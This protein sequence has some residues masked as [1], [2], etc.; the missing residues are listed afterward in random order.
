MTA[1][2]QND[3]DGWKLLAP[4]GFPD[5]AALHTLV[6]RE[7]QMLPLAGSPSLVIVGREV[8]LGTGIADLI[9]VDPKGRLAVIEVKLS[10]NAEARRAVIAQV[11]AYAAYLHGFSVSE[12][13]TLLA[14]HLQSRGYATLADMVAA[15]HQE[16]SFDVGEFNDALA[17]SLIE[18]RFRLVFVLDSAP[19]ELV[20]LS[21]FL[22]AVSEKLSIDL[23]A[24]ASYHVGGSQVVVPQRIAPEQRASIREQRPI[25]QRERGGGI[26][27]PG[28]SEFRRSIDDALPEF[29]PVLEAL[30]DWAEEM[31]AR[32]LATLASY[33]G[34][35][36]AVTLLPR[37]RPDNVG[38]IT[39]WNERG[40]AFLQYWR[41]VFERRAPTAI[42][43]IEREIAPAELKQGTYLRVHSLAESLLETLTS[44]YAEAN[45]VGAPIKLTLRDSGG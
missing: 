30:A 12:L 37:L 28:A 43:L 41:S 29:K 20:M 42:P 2:W 31:E 3:G 19:E 25:P 8:R 34:R 40:R 15:N 14:T 39:I 23:I 13:E 16:G 5:E 21:G 27:S 6:E 4:S 7:P 36:G 1:I 11:L 38:L 10:R 18:G 44:A 9:A 45:Q 17:A 22:E 32:N 35:S 24:V 26:L 33:V